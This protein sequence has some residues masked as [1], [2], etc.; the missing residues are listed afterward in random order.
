MQ[1][2]KFKK[3]ERICLIDEEGKPSFSSALLYDPA[4]LFQNFTKEKKKKS[5]S[6]DFGFK[7]I[8]VSQGLV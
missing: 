3:R 6:Q 1:K 4:F 7:E 5:R 8:A 2:L